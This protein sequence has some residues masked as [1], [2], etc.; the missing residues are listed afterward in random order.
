MGLVKVMDS[1][2][3]IGMAGSG[4]T[5]ISKALAEKLDTSFI[6]TDLLIEERFNQTLEELKKSKGYKFVRLAEESIILG[7]DNKADIISTGGSAIYSD[8]SMHH[9]TSFSK[10]FYIS[11]PLN[12][13]QQRI[14]TG[15]KRGL[16]VA[17]G[18]SVEDTFNERKPMY[19]KWAQETLDGSLTIDDLVNF[20][21]KNL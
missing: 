17:E 21:I 19:E 10:I 8:S 1:I 4:K 15:Q 9:L 20:I 13:I 16:A 18:T 11:T 6:D 12:I 5:T 2:S 3:F 14:G 7:L